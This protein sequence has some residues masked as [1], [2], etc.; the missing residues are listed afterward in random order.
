MSEEDGQEKTLDASPRKLEEARRRGDVPISRE[1]ASFGVHLAV[2]VAIG[3]GGHLLAGHLAAVLLP[4]IEQPEGWA[5]LNEVGLRDVGLG[6]AG[7]VALVLLPLLGLMIAGGLVPY[8]AQGS[9]V[10]AAERI[11]PKPSHLSPMRGLKRIF[12]LKALV[13][14]GKSLLKATASAGA[15]YLVIRPL[16]DRSPGFAALD[17]V[18]FV[19]L[20]R[21]VLLALLGTATLVYGVIAL[22]DVSFQQFEYRRRQRMSLQEMKEELRSTE[23]DPHAKAH[24][25]KLQRQGSKRRMLAEVPK[26]TV[27][28]ANPTHFAVALRYRR[29][30]DPAPVCVAKG[31]DAVALRIREAARAA[32][33]PVVEEKP[34]AR[35]L[36]ASVDIGDTIPKAHFEAVA[37]VI[38]IVWAQAGRKAA[39]R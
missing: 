31:V 13:E 10:V 38:G 14:F 26:A 8:L 27:V 15:A 30:E 28:I 9:C 16:F 24:R 33:V 22:F 17:P 32:G 36:H 19:P 20:A 1:G 35:A 2:L 4:F 34:L 11:R 5:D 18:A 12:G 29:G 6:L 39:R 37:K 3:L 25:R 23:G 21:E 7:A